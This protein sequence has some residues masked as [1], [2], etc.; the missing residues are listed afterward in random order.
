LF[1]CECTLHHECLDFHLSLDELTEHRDEFDV[2]SML[3]THLGR[4]MATLRG[5]CELETADDGLLVKL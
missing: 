5:Q 2:G 4:E 1:V 3:L